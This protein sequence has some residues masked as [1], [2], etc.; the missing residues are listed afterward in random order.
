[1]RI[2]YVS[3]DPG[4]PVFGRKGCS[5]HV[6]EIIAAF[7]RLGARVELFAARVEGDPAPPLR[8]VRVHPLPSAGTAGVAA[9]ERACIRAN[10]D[11]RDALARRGPFDLV[12]ERYSLWSF[13]AMQH[14]HACAVPGLL[15]I[16]A[17]LIEEQARHRALIHRRAAARVAVRAFAAAS[18]LVAVSDE[19]AAAIGAYND[20]PT[21]V[22]VVPNGVDVER[23]R[24]D[25]VPGCRELQDTFTVGFVGTLKPWH[26]LTTLVD[27]FDRLARRR[28]N[29]RLLVVGNGPGSRDLHED[30][31]RRN[32]LDLSVITGA[33]DTAKMPPL[34]TSMSVAVA[35]YADASGFYF[36][37]LKVFEY[38]AAGLPIVASRAGQLAAVIDE[39]I[40]GLLCPAGDAG[41]F[42]AA[43]D[44]LYEDA[45]LRSRLGNAARAK[46]ERQHSWDAVCARL[47]EIAGVRRVPAMEAIA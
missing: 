39:G 41:A 35:P 5:V 45:A 32:L 18:A 25:I 47:L 46:A 4:V 16:N 14:A 30:L 31:R 2:A 27:A 21:P 3:A 9:R 11:L 13:A 15:E 10:R 7:L 42:A 12:Y 24:P 44:R 38:M 17:P 34:L 37:P 8:S 36:S 22:H 20:G 26:G 43:L 40:T 23:F 29:V 1:M 28:A 6:Q 19:V 33:I